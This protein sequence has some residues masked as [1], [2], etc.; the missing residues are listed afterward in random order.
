MEVGIIERAFQ[1]ADQSRSVEDIRATLRKEGYTAV[2]E[3]LR[4][5]SL[6]RDL[7]KRINKSDE[8]QAKQ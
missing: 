5:G 8:P 2:D 7:L 6:R 3:H 1:L 4:S